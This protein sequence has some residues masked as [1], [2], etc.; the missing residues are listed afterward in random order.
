MKTE[1]LQ[2]CDLRP[3][4]AKADRKEAGKSPEG[5]YYLLVP[6]VQ[7]MLVLDFWPPEL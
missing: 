4:S 2:H 7:P 5:A 1:R 6:Q 3:T